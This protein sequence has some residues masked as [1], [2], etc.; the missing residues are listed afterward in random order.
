MGRNRHASNG[1]GRW[2][3]FIG[4]GGVAGDRAPR[5][6]LARGCRWCALPLMAARCVVCRPGRAPK[7]T[8]PDRRER[9][10][11]VP[12]RTPPVGDRRQT[13]PRSDSTNEKSGRIVAPMTH[14]AAGSHRAV[15]PMSVAEVEG[16]PGTTALRRV[17]VGCTSRGRRRRSSDHPVRMPAWARNELAARGTRRQLVSAPVRPIR[18]T[19]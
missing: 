11:A 19:M 8:A 17:I 10:G 16:P 2:L 3:G 9:T 18:R 5:S 13:A 12:G 7:Q 14:S 6:A 1:D 4:Q 15:T